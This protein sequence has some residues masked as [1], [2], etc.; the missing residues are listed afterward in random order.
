VTPS[1]H[2]SGLAAPLN[3]SH[4]KQDAE[5]AEQEDDEDDDEDE[6]NGHGGVPFVSATGTAGTARGPL[7]RQYQRRRAAGDGRL[8]VHLI[9]PALTE[10]DGAEL[11]TGSYTVPLRRARRGGSS[12][13]L[14]IADS[15]LS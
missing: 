10:R 8:N 4:E 3:L 11:V 7:P 1:S 9:S 12:R 13:R 15:R 6:P 2:D 5:P 14:P